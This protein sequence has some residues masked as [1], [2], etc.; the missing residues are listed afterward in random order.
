[1]FLEHVIS[2][3]YLKPDENKVKCIKEWPVLRNVHEVR[4]FCGFCYHYRRFSR[5]FSKS[6]AVI[7]RLLEAGQPSV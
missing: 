1:M 4:S 6:A 2:K 3:D 5:N 7:N